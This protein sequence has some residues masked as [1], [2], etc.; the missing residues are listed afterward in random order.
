M[1]TIDHPLDIS[2]FLRPLD[3]GDGVLEESRS[4][5]LSLHVSVEQVDV[6]IQCVD[7]L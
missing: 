2:K 4:S 5:G 1:S 6:E 7:V 3:V